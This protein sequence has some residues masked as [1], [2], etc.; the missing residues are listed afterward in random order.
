MKYFKIVVEGVRCLPCGKL[1][2]LHKQGKWISGLFMYEGD[3]IEFPVEL[4]ASI[5]E[6]LNSIKHKFINHS[7]HC[8][9][10]TAVTKVIVYNEALEKIASSKL[11]LE[12]NRLPQLKLSI[13]TEPVEA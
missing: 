5:E 11:L 8:Y 12:V 10:R 3:V 1:T 13:N 2:T 7:K 9:G 6:Q 4:V